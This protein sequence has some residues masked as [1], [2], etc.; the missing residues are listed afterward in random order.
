[1]KSK[2]VVRQDSAK[3]RTHGAVII[4]RVK[5]TFLHGPDLVVVEVLVVTLVLEDCIL[6]GFALVPILIITILI[7][8]T[9]DNIFVELI[10]V[11]RVDLLHL[12]L[13]LFVLSWIGLVL[14]LSDVLLHFKL[15][16]HQM[17]MD[18]TIAVAF[19]FQATD[20]DQG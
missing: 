17:D 19:L 5:F 7:V 3:V 13:L 20:A 1:M 15:V 11:I 10:I 9:V 2:V 16:A 18:K 12:A 4:V 14:F 6:L 8:L